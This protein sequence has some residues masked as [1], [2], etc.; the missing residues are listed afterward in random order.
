MQGLEA[1]LPATPSSARTARNLV[2][3]LLCDWDL[4][5]LTDDVL[6]VTSE[7]AANAIIASQRICAAAVAVSL[8]R[9]PDGLLVAIAD[10]A[11][12]GRLPAWLRSGPPPPRAGAGDDLDELAE[13]GR[14]LVLTGAV[15]D[16]LGWYRAGKWTVV[17]AEFRD[18]AGAAATA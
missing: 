18:P 8:A 13:H 1:Q 15:A 9:T 5:A 4:A 11:G 7:L 14:G 16:R 17:W 6:L 2:R 10:P 12:A 3:Q